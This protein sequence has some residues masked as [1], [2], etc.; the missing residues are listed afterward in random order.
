[1]TTMSEGELIGRIMN[2][3]REYARTNG[4]AH[5]NISEDTDL[6]AAGLLDS[7]SVVDLFVFLECLIGCKIDLTDVDLSEICV[8]RRLSKVALKG[9]QSY[10]LT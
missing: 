8:P 10:S 6:I 5:R 7:L 1:M 9:R 3:V 2:W 4:S